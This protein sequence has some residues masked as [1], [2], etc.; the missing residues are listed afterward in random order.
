[1]TRR[2]ARN[3][4]LAALCVG[5]GGYYVCRANLSVTTPLLLAEFGSRGLDSARL[6]TI[7][8]I[9]ILCYALMKP[10][11]GVLSDLWTG[12]GVFLAGMAAA[13]AATVAFGLGTGFATFAAA[14]AFNRLVQACGW[15]SLVKVVS[16][17]VDYRDYGTVMGFLSLSWL[18]GDVAG[19]EILGL[20]MER[21]LGW[22]EVFFASAGILGA[23]FVV[24]FAVLRE[25]PPEPPQVNP[26]NLFEHGD[27]SESPGM[28]ELLGTLLSSPAFWSVASM[29]CGMT[30]IRE[31]FNL[32]TPK[33]LTD[34]AAMAPARAAQWSGVYSSFGAL[35][36]IGA[37][38][39]TDRVFGGRRGLLLVVAN[40]LL[41][42]VLL[43]MASLQAGVSSWVPLALISLAG[44]IMMGPYSFLGGAMS[45]DLGG[46]HGSA[47]AAGL[48]DS[49][50]YLGGVLSGWAIGL[51]TQR[52]GWG[53]SFG[54]LAADAALMVAA[55]WYYWQHHER[56]KQP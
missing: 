44:F 10:F 53:A 27:Q 2:T 38:L 40:A 6:G 47:T 31:T 7:A 21:G 22:R 43:G 24:C 14:W 20:L 49:G 37:G 15:S 9:G 45:L 36:A 16:N 3:V 26:D 25:H 51:I 55:A 33:Y 12:R 30:L 1:M 8:S 29:C 32:W 35:S 34:V 39:L 17:W 19:R 11:G 50:G 13:I 48:V 41:C 46:R 5:Y 54:F 42:M 4:T 23:I 52:A 28:K 18:M 56:L